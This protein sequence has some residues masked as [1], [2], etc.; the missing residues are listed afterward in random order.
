MKVSTILNRISIKLGLLFSVVFLT[1]LLILGFILYGVFTNLFVDFVSSELMVRGSNHAKVLEN[2]YNKTM[3]DHIV[4]MEKGA[5]TH[6]IITDKKQNI[7]GSSVPPDPEMKKN[8]LKSNKTVKEI[9]TK[10]W[11]KDKYIISVSPISNKG[12]VYMFYPTDVLRET[13][14]VLKILILVTSIGTV[15]LAF[16]RDY[17]MMGHGFVHGYGGYGCGGLLPMLII[18]LVVG[19]L[20]YLIVKRPRRHKDH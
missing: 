11:K 14:S 16:G 20:V 5:A 7:L 19:L 10:D 9:V 2:D 3:V 13:V 12:Y 6:I 8:L 17:H 1:L 4:S 18:I 15:F